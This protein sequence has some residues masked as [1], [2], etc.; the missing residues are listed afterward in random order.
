MMMKVAY[1]IAC[2]GGLPLLESRK[3]NHRAVHKH[4]IERIN[5]F[6][7]VVGGGISQD[8]RW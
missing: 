5:S 7:L 2:F 3:W 1:Q 4:A 6:G 8:D